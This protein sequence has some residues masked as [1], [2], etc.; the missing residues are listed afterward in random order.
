MSIT[1]LKIAI[2]ELKKVLTVFHNM[3]ADVTTNKKLYTVVTD[4]FIRGWKL[5]IIYFLWCS[6]HSHTFLYQKMYD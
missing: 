6:L 1:V 2:Q 4:L 3:V 5:S